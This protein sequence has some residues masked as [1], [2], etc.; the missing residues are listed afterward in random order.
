[1]I[2]FV[3]CVVTNIILGPL[4]YFFL[5]KIVHVFLRIKTLKKLYNRILLRTQKR[6]HPYVEKYGLLGVAIFIGIPLPG[7]GS[8]SGALGSY[9]LGLGYK[10]FFWANV[11]GVLIA[12]VIVTL[13]VLSGAGAWSFLIKA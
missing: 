7:S 6:I 12:G 8:Y 13:V 1:M 9:V 11:L 4:I 10:R 2:V 5:D 3:V